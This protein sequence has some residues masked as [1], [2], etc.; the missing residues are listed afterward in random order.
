MDK[1]RKRLGQTQRHLGSHH[2]HD[3][4]SST[5]ATIEQTSYYKRHYIDR[6]RPITWRCTSLQVLGE[7]LTET[8]YEKSADGIAKITI[9]RPEKRNAFTPRTIIE[10]ISCLEDAKEDALVAAVILTGMG[11]EAFCSG[12]DQA[13]RDVGGYVGKDGVPR[14]NFL[15]LQVVLRRIPKPV[16]A[17]VAGHAVGGGH[18]IHMLCDMTISASNAIYGQTGPKVGSFDAGWGCSVMAR[19]IGPKRAKEMWFLCKLYTAEEA[20]EMGLV[21]KVVPLE[22]LEKETVHWCRQMLAN[23]PMALSVLKASM[24]AIDDGHA[25]VQQLGGLATKLYYSHEQG[26]EGLA[27]FKQK[28]KPDFG[29]FRK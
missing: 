22:E 23:S 7:P 21:N 16:I 20:Y 11:H 13:V 19:L 24:N 5:R 14:L 8:V 17:M 25:G 1:A 29:Q 18:I 3:L 15:D 28:R 26:L 12:G 10:L 6:D 27:A 2:D 9:N 4:G